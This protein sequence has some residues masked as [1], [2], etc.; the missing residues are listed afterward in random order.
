[1][2]DL[3]RSRE[4]WVVRG[5]AQRWCASGGGACGGGACG[6]GACG[7]GMPAAGCPRRVRGLWSRVRRRRRRAHGSRRKNMR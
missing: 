1:M 2:S 5:R 4:G 6:G 3:R 7:G